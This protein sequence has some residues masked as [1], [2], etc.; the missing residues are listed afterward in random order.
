M[1]D[2]R[3]PVGKFQKPEAFSPA[4]R[5]HCFD[6]LIAAPERI[7]D[8]VRGLSPDQL[9][10]PYR[11]GGW[12]VAQVVHHLADSHMHTY[13]RFKLALTEEAPTVSGYSEAAYANLAD[14]LAA[15]SDAVET[16]ILLISALHSRWVTMARALTEAEWNREFTIPGRPSRSLNLILA[17]Y[18][19]HVPHHV[20]HITSLRARMG[21]QR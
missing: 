11:E 8:A 9:A 18:T 16:S 1:E 15:T 10:T 19:W 20:A 3:Y 5:D 4:F 17:I 7:R 14:G 6:I 2:L 13:L 21:W 12:T